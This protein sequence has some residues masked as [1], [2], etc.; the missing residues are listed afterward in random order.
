MKVQRRFLTIIAL[1]AIAALVCLGHL[2]S[3]QRAKAFVSH[4]GDA[5]AQATD[6][7]SPK[8]HVI[9]CIVEVPNAKPNATYKFVWGRNDPAH[10]SPQTI[11]QEQVTYQSGNRVVSKL[12]SSDDLPEGDYSVN[13]WA[14]AS[15]MRAAF[16]VK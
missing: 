8:D 3:A 6:T 10:S 15:H 14:A 1:A 2:A 5:N 7:F 11:F 12:S 16:T 9:F 13:V 4:A